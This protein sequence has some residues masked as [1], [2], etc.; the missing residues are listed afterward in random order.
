M[1]TMFDFFKAHDLYHT[2]EVANA[3]ISTNEW[4]F[5]HGFRAEE[6]AKRAPIVVRSLTGK[7]LQKYSS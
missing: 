6:N 3:R 4:N 7:D 2:D 1:K 5:Y